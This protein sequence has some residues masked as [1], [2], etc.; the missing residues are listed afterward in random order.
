MIKNL[1]DIKEK[2][3]ILGIVG[4]ITEVKR[5]GSTYM[6]KCPLHADGAPSMAINPKKGVWHCF[7]GC[8]GGDVLSF[9]QKYHNW[10]F[11]TAVEFLAKES[12]IRPEYSQNREATRAD[13]E[14]AR[15]E[16][17][18]FLSVHKRAHDFYRKQT[19]D[20]INKVFPNCEKIDVDGRHYS[21]TT[22]EAYQVSFVAPNSILKQSDSHDLTLGD[23]Q[24]TG[25]VKESQQG[26]GG[27]YDNFSNRI[28][29]PWIDLSGNVIGFTGRKALDN[30][31]NTAKYKNSDS[32]PIFD[33]GKELFG[34]WQAAKEITKQETIYIVEGQHDAMSLYEYGYKNVLATSGTALTP[35]HAK[36]LSRLT[37]NVILL[38]DGDEAGIKATA[39]A[40]IN[41]SEH[42]A[43]KVALIPI[44][45]DADGNA[46]KT[47]PCQLIRDIGKEQFDLFLNS[48]TQDG[49]T[50][51][52]MKDYKPGDTFSLEQTINR[53]AEI[54]APLP[55]LRR[56][57]QLKAITDR[58]K[59]GSVKALIEEAINGL[60]AQQ[61][62]GKGYTKEQQEK[63]GRY[64]VYSIDNKYMVPSGIEGMGSPIS[65]FT[66]KSML[67]IVGNSASERVVEISNDTGFE[68]MDKI[69]SDT[70]TDQQAF[71]K[72][73]ESKGNFVLN[74]TKETWNRIRRW[75]YDEMVTAYPITVLGY[76]KEG[77]FTWKNGIWNG[78]H[79]IHADERGIVQH[80]GNHY[81]IMESANFDNQYADD[82]EDNIISGKFFLHK[83]PITPYTVEQWGNL[84]IKAYG[85]KS[86]ILIAYCFAAM[87]RD[88]IFQKFTF[89]PHFNVFGN[90]G[91]GKNWLIESAMSLF[92]RAEQPTDLTNMTDKALSRVLAKYRNALT[93]TDEYRNEIDPNVIHVLR[94]AYGGSGR[95]TAERS[96]DTRTRRTEPKS[97]VIISGEHRPTFNIA[98]YKRCVAIETTSSVFSDEQTKAAETL[99]DLEQTGMFTT[100]THDLQQYREAVIDNIPRYFTD[101][102]KAIKINIAGD[103]QED[104]ITNN[105]AILGAVCSILKDQG[106][107]LPFTIAD[108]IDLL[109]E[110][111]TYQSAI[112][113]T[114][115]PIASFWR[116]VAFLLER[117]LIHHNKDVIIQSTDNVR[118]KNPRWKRGDTNQKETYEEVF[119][120]IKKILFLRMQVVHPLYLEHFA[121]QNRGTGMALGTLEHYLY[122]SKWFLGH[123]KSKKFDSTSY[124]CLVF[125]LDDD[126]PVELAFSNNIGTDDEF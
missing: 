41:L 16:K 61:S 57:T 3:D 69:P 25:L 71:I 40:V 2:S 28:I 90:P 111:V 82:R 119:N 6:C 112:V 12:G 123:C 115:D 27:F 84:M 107:V 23:L 45:L 79:F 21:R 87:Y 86:I 114:E 43:V 42:V 92:G 60:L 26:S 68:V 44:D 72:Y 98:L 10:D 8:G 104:R 51:A 124:S 32:S 30:H 34:V 122:S 37:D 89:F 13:Y 126:F 46:K 47:D 55:M 85:Q 38:F 110:R 17:D 49:I 97:G 5:V 77:F 103:Y 108:L 4:K 106:V 100:I 113:T 11:I 33:K 121:K 36:F 64:G 22:L 58:K 56:E 96:M 118:L 62:T 67:L 50:W 105:Y 80:G 9:L 94:G 18:L 31:S 81:L 48:Y 120:A 1:D 7:A 83:Q 125:C 78:V 93:W 101:T 54:L 102:R 74:C 15:K 35:H 39:K 75:V 24:K 63:I 53:A 19:W 109:S 52:I 91:S 95:T 117:S 20:E 29:F 14:S 116:T 65:N 88:I 99:K 70:F 59:L 73:I 76:H 66:I